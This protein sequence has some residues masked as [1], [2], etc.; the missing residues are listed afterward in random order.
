MTSVHNFRL[1]LKKKMAS[2][3]PEKPTN[4]SI[5]IAKT[6][7][8]WQRCVLDTLRELYEVSTK[9]DR[10]FWVDGEEMGFEQ[11]SGPAEVFI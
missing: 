7:P 1:S 4:G 3:N 8:P 10:C 5:W 6:F 2:K 11:G 9:F